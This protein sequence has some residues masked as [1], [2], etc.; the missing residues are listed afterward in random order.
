VLT[1][2]DH[3]PRTAE[4][5]TAEADGSAEA[6]WRSTRGVL[7]RAENLEYMRLLPDDCCD[8]IYADPPYGS[9]RRRTSERCAEGFDDRWPKDISHYLSFMKP[10]FEQMHRLLSNRGSLY[11]H[12][13]WRAVHYAKVALDD[14][15]GRENFLNE[16][17]WS[18]RTGG[19]SS[20]WF[21]RKHDTILMYAKHAGSHT[22]NVLRDG[23]FRTDGLKHDEDGRPFKSTRRGKLYFHAD[24]PAMTDVWEVP[25]L[26]TVSNERT[27]YPSQKPEA[28]LERVVAAG[29]NPG[30][31]VADFFCGSGTT[32]AV[33][34]RLGR[35]W[36]GCDIE[37]EA[38]RI[39]SLRLNL[40]GLFTG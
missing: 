40:N 9:G 20:R 8:L 10:R 34:D 14:I 22:F 30:D 37:P 13:D 4:S 28:L 2:N 39:A 19:R 27:G 21:A 18:Y 1:G 29:S 23:T 35:Q 33:A 12:L 3:S 6:V 11:V 36:M 31:V 25:F 16:I 5:L 7:A 38:V 32:L 24:G 26:S 17:I 15:F